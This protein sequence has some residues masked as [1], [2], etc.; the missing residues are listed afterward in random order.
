MKK[1]VIQLILDCI[2]NQN[3]N[4]LECN[5]IVEETTMLIGQDSCFGSLSL[6]NL[7]I[8]I[9]EKVYE[10]FETRID[11]VDEKALGRPDSP[12][13]NVE[14]LASFISDTISS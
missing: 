14:S 5:I 3:K 13:K 2:K 6:A 1:E 8:S 9:E 4:D 11:L 7:L 10:R 12:Y